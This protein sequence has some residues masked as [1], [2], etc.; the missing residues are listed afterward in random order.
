[1]STADFI[2]QVIAPYSWNDFIIIIQTKSINSV[3]PSFIR[4]EA[5][6]ITYSLH[7]ILRFDIEKLIFNEKIELSELPQI[8]NE[9]TELFLGLIPPNDSKGILQ[10]VHW[11]GGAFGYFPTYCLGNLYA[12]QIYDNILKENSSI[13]FYSL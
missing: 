3:K 7:I 12:S 9:K 4:V 5:D 11:S 10:D 2:I 8:W 6:E 13:S 1:M